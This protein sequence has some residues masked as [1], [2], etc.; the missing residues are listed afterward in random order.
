MTID[1]LLY[2]KHV[3]DVSLM[4]VRWEDEANDHY[5]NGN[6]AR[7][8]YIHRWRAAVYQNMLGQHS[9]SGPFDRWL[10]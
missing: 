6:K 1:D 4:L 8:A 5:I 9:L 7:A 2:R 3:K 10:A